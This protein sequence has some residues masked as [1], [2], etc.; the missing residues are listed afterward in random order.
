M[1]NLQSSLQ[2]L[3]PY[4]IGYPGGNSTLPLYAAGQDR[5][6]Y[7]YSKPR[8]DLPIRRHWNS[9]GVFQRGASAQTITVEINIPVDGNRPM[10]AGFFAT[11]PRVGAT[12]LMHNGAV[13]G[14]RKGIGQEAFL[15]FAGMDEITASTSNGERRGLVIGNVRDPN[16]A[17][18]IWNY[19][20]LVKEFKERAV[21]GTLP[22][23]DANDTGDPSY[24]PEYWGQKS[25]KRVTFDYI[26][27]HGLV[28]HQLRRELEAKRTVDERIGNS[29]LIDL[30]VQKGPERVAVYEV[31]TSVDRQSLY[32]GI[33]QLLVHGSSGTVKRIL[34][35]P[36]EESLPHDVASAIAELGI[37]A[38]RFE[39]EGEGAT[40]RVKLH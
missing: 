14:G 35:L 36:A 10:V 22:H 1:R 5:L 7:S 21:T 34:L 40:A 32:T 30:Y 24:D 37:E 8:D 4:V 3:G 33:G 12:F 27:Y 25:G 15:G 11:D 17:A 31:K 23:Q 2:P 38:R 16:L 19:V 28:V 26:A 18:L 9:F 13:G 6:Y 20:L 39:I 29:R